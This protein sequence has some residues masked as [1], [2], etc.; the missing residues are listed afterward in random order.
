[1]PEVVVWWLAESVDLGSNPSST[2]EEMTWAILDHD[3]I[4]KGHQ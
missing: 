3:L 4:M 2:F 1:M